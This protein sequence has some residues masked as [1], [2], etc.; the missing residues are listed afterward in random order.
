[1]ARYLLSHKLRQTLEDGTSMEA[2][3]V[4]DADPVEGRR[5]YDLQIALKD[6]LE[7][8]DEVAP[9]SIVGRLQRNELRVDADPPRTVCTLDAPCDGASLPRHGAMSGHN[10][11]SIS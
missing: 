7:S 11:F 4:A 9:R 3:A 10:D 5:R 1:M 2:I 6:V 8:A